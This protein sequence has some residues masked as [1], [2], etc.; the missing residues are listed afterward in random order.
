[1]TFGKISCNISNLLPIAFYSQMKT[2]LADPEV[3]N[4]MNQIR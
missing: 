3:N 2:Y 1:M 4:H